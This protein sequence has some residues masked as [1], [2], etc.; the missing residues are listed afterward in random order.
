MNESGEQCMAYIANRE[1]FLSC[2][3]CLRSRSSHQMALESVQRQWFLLI[4][5]EWRASVRARLLLLGVDIGATLF[6]VDPIN[7]F[8]W[9]K[10]CAKVVQCNSPCSFFWHFY[11]IWSVSGGRIFLQ[12]LGNSFTLAFVD[13]R[14]IAWICIQILPNRIS[15]LGKFFSCSCR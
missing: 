10:A 14:L 3:G 11:C 7:R 9:T 12:R 1:Y 6:A 8:V 4:L 13:G 5:F 15:P 2:V